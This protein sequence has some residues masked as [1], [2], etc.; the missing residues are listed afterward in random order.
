M[1]YDNNS[2]ELQYRATRGKEMAG[3]LQHVPCT[4]H[5]TSLNLVFSRIYLPSLYFCSL[6]YAL[7]CEA[8]RQQR[9]EWV[10]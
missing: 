9:R 10:S 1:K 5:C 7:S 3:I 8:K 6:S 2:Q 4:H